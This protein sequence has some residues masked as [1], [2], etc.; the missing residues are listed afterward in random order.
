MSK[1]YIEPF[2]I[3]N[4]VPQLFIPYFTLKLF[5]VKSR[6]RR[7]TSKSRLLLAPHFLGKR[8]PRFLQQ[9]VSEI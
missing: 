3:F 6:S 5:V 4:A 7:K 9:F 2:V 1:Q 8:S